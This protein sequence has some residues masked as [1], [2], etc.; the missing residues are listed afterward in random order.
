[1]HYLTRAAKRI[2]PK[3]GDLVYCG[4]TDAFT[5]RQ[6]PD[7]GADDYVIAGRTRPSWMD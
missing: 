6:I 4:S 7:A 3:P 2:S 5:H 1:M